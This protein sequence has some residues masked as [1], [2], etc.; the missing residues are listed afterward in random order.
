MAQTVQTAASVL[1][2]TTGCSR[3]GK[4]NEINKNVCERSGRK[5]QIID[6]YLIGSI[7]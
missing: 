6:E 1:R 7:V 3:T 4:R 2:E 5:M